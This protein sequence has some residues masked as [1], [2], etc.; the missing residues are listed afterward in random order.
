M[1]VSRLLS[2]VAKRDE[3]SNTTFPWGAF[4]FWGTARPLTALVHIARPATGGWEPPLHRVKRIYPAPQSQHLAG[5]S[6]PAACPKTETHPFPC[7]PERGTRPAREQGEAPPCRRYRRGDVGKQVEAGR[8]DSP[9]R[10]YPIT[11]CAARQVRSRAVVGPRHPHSVYGA[12]GS[13]RSAEARG[14]RNSQVLRADL[15]PRPTA[16]RAHQAFQVN[17]TKSVVKRRELC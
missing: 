11:G 7:R 8:R 5:G 17:R 13:W 1:D 2:I 3:L 10:S 9:S 16:G 14:R 4:Q 12:S 15:P 6:G